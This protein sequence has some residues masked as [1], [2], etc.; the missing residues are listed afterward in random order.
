MRQVAAAFNT[1]AATLRQ[2]LYC[3]VDDARM[4]VNHLV[5]VG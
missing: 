3:F 1:S 2:G 5:F 4:T